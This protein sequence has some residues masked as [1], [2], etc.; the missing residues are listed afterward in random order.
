MGC[1]CSPGAAIGLLTV[2]ELQYAC[3]VRNRSEKN[4]GHPKVVA[5]PKRLLGAFD[6]NQKLGNYRQL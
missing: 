5:I 4:P 6:I 3:T 1:G 2:V